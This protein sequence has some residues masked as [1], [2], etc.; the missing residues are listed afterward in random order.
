VQSGENSGPATDGLA[1]SW[2]L[3][4][5]RRDPP[6]VAA[7]LGWELVA[8]DP[9]A[10]TAEV[11]FTA[12]EQFLNSAGNVQGG[13]LAAMLDATLGPTLIATLEAGQWA[14][15]IDLQVQFLTPAKAGRLRGRG[16]VVRR[17]RDIAF[18]A[19]ELCDDE[20]QVV[21]TATA[22]AIIRPTAD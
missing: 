7:M 2:E 3:L 16:R 5:G 6:P 11:S 19:G 4:G 17:G 18:L 22:T 13:L 1:A 15:T 21:A 8:V 9:D 14:P 10:G 12:A 20:G